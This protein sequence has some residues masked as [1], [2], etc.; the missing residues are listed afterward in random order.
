MA[1]GAEIALFAADERCAAAF[2]RASLCDLV[3]GL[4]VVA[5]AKTS[6]KFTSCRKL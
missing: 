4:E 3:I 6:L 2:L 5:S 1:V